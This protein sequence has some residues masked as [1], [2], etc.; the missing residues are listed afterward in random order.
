MNRH[1]EALP[2]SSSEKWSD[3]QVLRVVNYG[4][5]LLSIRT[6]LAL[7]GTDGRMRA[8]IRDGF[9]Y[10]N[11]FSSRNQDSSFTHNP[12]IAPLINTFL[13]LA[14]ETNIQNQLGGP[15]I[16]KM[17]PLSRGS[18]DLTDR[19]HTFGEVLTK[20]SYHVY[21][22]AC[23]LP[24]GAL[25][26]EEKNQARISAEYAHGITNPFQL[27]E[28]NRSEAVRRL[29]E[30]RYLKLPSVMDTESSRHSKSGLQK[31]LLAATLVVG[32]LTTAVYLDFPPGIAQN[33][34]QILS[35]LAQTTEQL[36]REYLP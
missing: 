3:E 14:D 33:A 31:A 5:R 19:F 28:Y 21:P 35:S 10:Q 4:G 25:I 6:R 23:L 15:D 13:Q 22:E 30:M 12:D 17:D 36:K 16:G 8:I 27:I 24:E 7:S 32:A 2:V 20:Y 9:Y 11:Q 18:R 29:R 26:E 1:L 34:E